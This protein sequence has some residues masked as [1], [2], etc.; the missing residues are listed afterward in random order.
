MDPEPGTRASARRTGGHALR[1]LVD[2]GALPRGGV[3]D[4]EHGKVLWTYGTDLGGGDVCD[5]EACTFQIPETLG[6]VLRHGLAGA[7]RVIWV[8]HFAAE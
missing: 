6:V 5:G 7:D 2:S 1:D 8:V 3:I 4:G